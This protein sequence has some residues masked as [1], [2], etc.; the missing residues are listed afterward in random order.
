[1]ES[2]KWELKEH[3]DDDSYYTEITNGK[4]S[5]CTQDECDDMELLP[6]VVSL[7]NESKCSFYSNNVLELNQHLEIMSLQDQVSRLKEVL[8]NP[9]TS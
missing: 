6:K 7:L 8:A 4:I 5:I 2:K 9:L 3:Q 1:M